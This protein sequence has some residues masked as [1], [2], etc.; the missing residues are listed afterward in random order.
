MTA[1]TGASAGEVA[2]SCAT[3]GKGGD[4]VD[5]PTDSLASQGSLVHDDPGCSAVTAGSGTVTSFRVEG[6]YLTV[7]QVA[8]S[9]GDLPSSI[10]V[11]GRIAYVMNAGGADSVQGFRLTAD[12]L[13]PLPD[14]RR[15]PPSPP[16]PPKSSR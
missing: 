4:Q 3:S 2:G 10:A 1:V 16:T 6:R 12:G 11:S 15:S 5:A 13:A 9:G 8:G 14:T 7:R